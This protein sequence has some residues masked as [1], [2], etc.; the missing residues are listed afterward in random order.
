MAYTI[1]ASFIFF[2]ISIVFVPVI[3][4]L[5]TNPKWHKAALKVHMAWARTYF[6]LA[7]FKVQIEGNEYLE[8]NQQYIFCANHFSYIDIAAFY[9]LHHGKFI[10][11]SS[12]GKIPIF[13]YFFR[14]MHISVNRASARSRGDSL[15]LAKEELLK[16]FNLSIYPEG[17]MLVKEEDL[18]YMVNFKDGAFKLAIE[19]QIPIVP[20]VYPNNFLIIPDRSPIRIH[21]H[22][23]IIKVL[24]PIWPRSAEESE[25]QRL[26]VDTYEAIQSELLRYHPDKVKAVD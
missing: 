8:K 21:R 4:L 5:S 18:P 14:K 12:V 23:L 22:D 25:T 10:G 2:L 17:G 7:L 1:Y 24:E 19:F 9:L 11:K 16:G 26:K 20:V 3:N 6:K 13:G 15:R